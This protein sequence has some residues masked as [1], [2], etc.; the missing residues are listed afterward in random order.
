MTA[1]PQVE[2]KHL[3]CHLVAGSSMG[4]KPGL[5]HSS[6]ENLGSRDNHAIAVWQP[7]SPVAGPDYLSHPG[8]H[9]ANG[10]QAASATPGCRENGKISTNAALAIIVKYGGAGAIIYGAALLSEDLSSESPTGPDN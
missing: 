7:P 4:H 8:N 9:K 6:A 3:D 1:P 10:R 2:P 5:L